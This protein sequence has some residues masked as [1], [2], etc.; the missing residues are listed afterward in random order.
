MYK[1]GVVLGGRPTVLAS[2]QPCLKNTVAHEAMHSVYKTFPLRLIPGSEPAQGWG[3]GQLYYGS[4]GDWTMN[5]G[6]TVSEH[7]GMQ[8]Y[9]DTCINCGTQ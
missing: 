8:P 7:D 4:M 3:A 6:G 1:E 9:L 5:K 2:Y